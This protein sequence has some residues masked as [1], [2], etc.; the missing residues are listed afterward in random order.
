MS[1]Y[2]GNYGNAPYNLPYNTTQQPH[3]HVNT[4][5]QQQP[6]SPQ[7]QPPSNTIVDYHQYIQQQGQGNG[8]DYPPQQ[9]QYGTQVIAGQTVHVVPHGMYLLLLLF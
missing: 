1:D 9:P 3:L 4:G 5:T 7:S 6:L 2:P 8:S